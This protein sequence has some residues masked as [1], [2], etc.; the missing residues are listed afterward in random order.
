[1]R[2]SQG[3][4]A[5]V[6]TLTACSGKTRPFADGPIEGL[7]GSGGSGGSSTS[8]ETSP[9]SGGNPAP[10]EG[11]PVGGTA[12]GTTLPPDAG[13]E[14]TCIPGPRDCTSPLDN[15]CDGRPDDD[16]WDDVCLCV[17]GLV[18]ACEEHPDL[19]GRGPCRDGTRTCVSTAG[20]AST[21]WGPCE[22]SVGPA[23]ADSCEPGNDADC[24]GTAN[25]GCSCVDGFTQSCGPASALGRCEFGVQSC[26]G[27]TIGSC[28][29]AVFPLARNCASPG[30]DDCDGRPDNL[31]DAF[32][33]CVPGQ[34]NGPCSGSPNT[35][36]CG[37]A[38]R[39]EPCL[40]DVDCSL[41]SGGRV[42]CDDGRCIV[43]LL[44]P[45]ATCQGGA[46]C[47]SGRCLTWY[48]DRDG[49]LVGGS[50]DVV[51]TCAA[52]TGTST[53]P[54]GYVADEG[55]CCDL[56]GPNRAVAATVFPGQTAFFTGQQTVCPG[57][58]PFDYD[59]SD[60]VEY[61][62]QDD[63]AEY[64]GSCL[65]IPEDDC[66]GAG[67]RMWSSGTAPACG[68]LGAIVLCD[69][70][71]FMGISTCQAIVGAGNFRNECH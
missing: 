12:V 16:V 31:I 30:D 4:Y 24:D 67:I 64:G 13:L 14:P 23:D 33:Q 70:R 50:S 25:E 65:E 49:D 42:S 3:I 53:P 26:E 17:P 10:A 34:G 47:E 7:G 40:S 35:A 32:C 46:E 58:A 44:A 2:A 5:L 15:D 20:N 69:V 19:D 41:V 61:L 9:G 43:P 51:L 18:E 29:G 27:G 63:T 45:G 21:G 38:G 6:I 55:D 39:C 1:L 57:V 60:N 37:A 22:G 54:S 11:E 66:R 8:T 52:L 59:C 56:D 48:R 28:E 68:V 36:R 62:L 71:T